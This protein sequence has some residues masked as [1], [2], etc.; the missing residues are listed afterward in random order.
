MFS[1]TISYFLLF[2]L[3]FFFQACAKVVPLNEVKVRRA[4][5]PFAEESE[6]NEIQKIL[7]FEY[8]VAQKTYLS[9]SELESDYGD[10][11]SI[12]NKKIVGVQSSFND[13]KLSLYVDTKSLGKPILVNGIIL[14]KERLEELKKILRESGYA[15]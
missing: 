10:V 4:L 15:F 8:I 9:Y 1:K 2:A 12:M 7:L 3:T 13:E 6:L 5:E 11:Q 14:S